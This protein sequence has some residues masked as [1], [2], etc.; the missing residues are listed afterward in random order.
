MR[1]RRR[2]GALAAV[3]AES[4]YGLSYVLTRA[5]LEAVSP[6]TLLAWRFDVA[7][8][9]MLVLVATGVL[10]L[11]LDRRTL[12]A[13]G[14]LALLDPVAYYVAE[15][16]GVQRTSASVSGLVLSAIPV[17]SLV[18]SA[19]LL[20]RRPSGRQVAGVLV[21]LV[22][23]AA[24]VLATGGSG[25]A[26]AVGHLLLLGAVL[27]FALYS[28]AAERADHVPDTDKAFAMVLAGAVAFTA[29][30]LAGPR[31]DLL[32]PVH[33]AGVGISVL[34]LA[35]GSSVGAYLL[36][37]S[38]IRSL[39]AGGY[40]TFIGVSTLVALLAGAVVLGE[41][42]AP[43]QWAGGAAILVGVSI[44]NRTGGQDAST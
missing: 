21:T 22:G 29:A 15:T 11:H 33:D 24:T 43:W 16:L 9:L 31:T 23:V 10:R 13:L 38:A 28:V 12:P 35:A 25:S 34:V 1:P 26:G 32:V 3:A 6:T 7:L 39:G 4:L 2:Q 37:N 8:V 20:G 17:A 44:A 5:S 42:L 36:Q 27:A 40:S 14:L 41:R 18:A 19:L 30:S